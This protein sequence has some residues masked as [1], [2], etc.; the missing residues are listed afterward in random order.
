MAGSWCARGREEEEFASVASGRADDYRVAWTCWHGE[1]HTVVLKEARG[2]AS[3]EQRRE[4]F[5]L[6]THLLGAPRLAVLI[7]V[8]LKLLR[9]CR[10]TIEAVELVVHAIWCG[11]LVTKVKLARS[12]HGSIRAWR[13]Y[14]SAQRDAPGGS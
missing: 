6:S 14:L 13:A 3:L 5:G 11:Q 9:S 10:G 12:G 2:T 1:R 7:G 4:F 8:D